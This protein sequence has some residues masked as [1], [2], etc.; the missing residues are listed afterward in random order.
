MAK[1]LVQAIMLVRDWDE[2]GQLVTYYKG[3]WFRVVKRRAR[4]LLET[5]QVRIPGTEDSREAV[6]GDLSD[7]GVLIVGDGETNVAAICGRYHLQHTNGEFPTLPYDRTLIWMARYPMTPQR[8]ALGIVRVAD[9]DEKD[10]YPGWEAAAMLRHADTLAKD[11]GSAED[12]AGTLE[13]FGDLRLAVYESGAVWI[14]K[15]RSTNAMVEAWAGLL[16]DGVGPEHAFLRALYAKPIILCTLPEG[17]LA[18]W[19]EA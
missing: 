2:H 11:V 18:S 1:V 7:A 12:Q 6:V 19:I 5:G 14:R 4:E 17:W 15:T 10:G 16:R 8:A 13:L 9:S 3:D